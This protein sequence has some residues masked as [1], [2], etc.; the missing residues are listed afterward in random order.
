MKNTNRA[1]MAVIC[2]LFLL[3]GVCLYAPSQVNASASKALDLEQ[4]EQTFAQAIKNGKQTVT[5]SA[6]AS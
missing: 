5:F 4:I 1:I 6:P 2:F 3:A